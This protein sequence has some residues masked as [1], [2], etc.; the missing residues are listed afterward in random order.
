MDAQKNE[1]NS[2]AEKLVSVV[3]F[4]KWTSS[5][6]EGFI[7]QT[8]VPLP[9]V[10]LMPALSNLFGVAR[11]DAGWMLTMHEGE[12]KWLRNFPFSAAFVGFDDELLLVSGDFTLLDVPFQQIGV[13]IFIP[14]P[15][16]RES[17]AKDEVLGFGLVVS[18]DTSEIERVNRIVPMY[19]PKRYES[20]K[21]A[22]LINR[23]S[24]LFV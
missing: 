3:D 1:F 15:A 12:G 8:E 22:N 16:V 20:A 11:D 17:L 6:G 4:I 5:F 7:R 10:R 21:V 9:G 13:S 18:G 23:P 19:D 24:G 2:L 14:D